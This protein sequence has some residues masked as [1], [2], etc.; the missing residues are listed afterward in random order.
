MVHG[1]Y[2]SVRTGVVGGEKWTKKKERPGQGFWIRDCL[3]R[4]AQAGL[5]V[6]FLRQAD[7]RLVT[8]Q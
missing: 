4:N 2:V 5:I 3:V 1:S 6:A 8:H 7:I